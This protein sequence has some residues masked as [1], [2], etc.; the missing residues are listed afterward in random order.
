MRNRV[1]NWARAGHRTITGKCPCG[2]SGDMSG[3]R[4]HLTGP[5]R[6]C[7]SGDFT[8]PDHGPMVS[9]TRVTRDRAH[10]TDGGTF[11]L[12]IEQGTTVVRAMSRGVLADAAGTGY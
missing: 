3:V 6:A 8:C 1:L 12:L 10:V 11:D 9:S 7:L 5:D 4:V 2:L